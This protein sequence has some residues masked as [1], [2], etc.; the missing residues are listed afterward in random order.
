M[1]GAENTHTTETALKDNSIIYTIKKS[2]C[3]TK[4]Q[5]KFAYKNIRQYAQKK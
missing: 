3:D 5:K 4:L 2:K 1:R